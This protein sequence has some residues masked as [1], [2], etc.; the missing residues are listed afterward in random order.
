MHYAAASAYSKTA[1]TT[2]SPRELEAS[3]LTK[4]AHRLQAAAQNWSAGTE[5][6]VE[7]LTYNRRI[8][9]VLA[10]AAT[11]PES[12]LPSTVKANIAQLAAFIFHRTLSIQLEPAPDKLA[13][14]VRIN[15][16]IAA[17]LRSQPQAA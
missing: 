8:W 12:P 17:G 5:G 2:Q 7:A 9:T 14:L 1:Q 4:A 13:V 11:E 3:L 16:E 10:A 6:L 15:R